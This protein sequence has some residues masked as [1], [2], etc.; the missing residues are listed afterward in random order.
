LVLARGL[1][2]DA[3]LPE[4]LP[5]PLACVAVADDDGDLVR[6][7]E[8]GELLDDVLRGERR[9]P[10]AD[11]VEDDQVALPVG[12]RQGERVGRPAGGIHEGVVVEVGNRRP[13]PDVP[14]D[15]GLEGLAGYSALDV[16]PKLS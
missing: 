1:V 12:D 3:V 10:L 7:Q 8:L 16:G 11:R 5:R 9:P 2:G 14:G 13:L 15:A 6:F 4:P